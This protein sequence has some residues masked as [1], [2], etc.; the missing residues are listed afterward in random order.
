[1]KTVFNVRDYGIIHDTN[2]L[3][4]EK[5]QGVLDIAGKEGGIVVFP[6]G[7]YRTGGL[8]LH[9]RTEVHLESGAS[10]IGSEDPEDYQVFPI[11]EGVLLHTD[12]EMV[13]GYFAER[14][15][16]RAEYRRALISAYGEEDIT[17]T[18]EGENSA[19][20][21]M[22]CFDPEGE[23]H[24][25]GP[26]GIFL[27]N[28]KGVK[29]HDYVIRNCG[30][31]HHQ[32]DT[33]DGVSVSMVT[34]LGGHD[35]FHLHCCRDVDIGNCTIHT[36]DDCVAGMNL[37]NLHIHDSDLNTSC[38]VFR[39]GGNHILVENCR[40]WGPGI[41]PY[42]KSVVIDRDHILPRTQGHHDINSLI[43]YFASEAFPIDASGD[44][45][46]RNCTIENPGKL[47]F[48]DYTASTADHGCH[49]CKGAPLRS[50]VFRDCTING[51]CGPSVIH[52]DPCAPL[53]IRLIHVSG[54]LTSHRE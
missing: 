15:N 20:D 22:D 14:K 31:F 27:S 10:L 37:E 7:N 48:Y 36:G 18:G 5:I 32:I 11:P 33:S 26:H 29:L 42:R 1:M 51:R 8:L 4:T 13:P 47:L 34:I 44:I 6:A 24:I 53:S 12:M 3:Q 43:E 52:A 16:V 35:G 21:G 49:F 46:L 17:I 41:Y 45:E 30:N 9:S 23:E 2:A 39:I 25:R 38:Q 50:V 28:C 19:I 54:E 40:L